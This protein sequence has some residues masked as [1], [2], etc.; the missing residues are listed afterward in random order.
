MKANGASSFP[1]EGKDL[2]TESRQRSRSSTAERGRA[3]LHIHTSFSDGWPGP[4]D[5]VRRARQLGLAVVAITDHDT[6]EGALW[7]ADFANGSG[8]APHV[9]VGEEVSTRQGHVVGLFLQKRV[10][11]GQSAAATV[12][13]IH[14]QG[15]IA[16]APHP[17]WRTQS[18][19]RARPV[20]GVG[21]QAAE[22]DFD[23]IEVEN[24][25][26]GFYLFNQMA[27]RLNQDGG[28][29]VLGNSDAHILDAIARSYTSFPGHTAAALR[30]AIE[31]R[32][33]RAHRQRYPPL[34]LVRYAAWGIEH[35]RLRRLAQ[36]RRS[37]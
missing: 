32:R 9:I 30:R 22:L 36:T 21:W 31:G 10:Q 8:Q 26:P 20:H 23:A 37:A 2:K 18:Q 14:E 33:T 16:F 11:P 4:V 24:S 15:G 13:A 7:A 34:A 19:A 6:I 5:V 17:F 25:T 1:D 29:A 3:D 35:R 28:R 27:Q 12:A